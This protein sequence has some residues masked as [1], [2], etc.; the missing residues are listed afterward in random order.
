MSASTSS[1]RLG[2]PELVGEVG[3]VGLLAAAVALGSQG[4]LIGPV[5]LVAAVGVIAWR[6]LV[7]WHALL[8]AMIYVILFIPIRT[9]SLPGSLPIDLEPYRL[10]VAVVAGAWLAASLYDPRVRLYR[11]GVIDAPLTAFLVIVLVSVMVNLGRVRSVGSDAIKA[12]LFLATFVLVVYLVA[13]LVRTQEDLDRVV[14]VLVNGGA[15]VALACLIERRT[16]YNVFNHLSQVMPILKHSV[17]PVLIPDAR[18]A[19]VLGSS[20]HPI[21]MGVALVMLVPLA[22][23]RAFTTGGRL[24]WAAAALMVMGAMGTISR[25]AIVALGATALTMIVLK[26]RQMK[27][28]WP[29]IIPGLLLVHVAMPGT[30]GTIRAAF[31]PASGLIAQQSAAPVGSGRLA[32]LKPALRKE[33]LPDPLI[34]EGFGTRVTTP[35]SAVPVPNAPILDDEWLGILLET[36]AAGALAFL[37]IFVRFVRR[38]GGAARRDETSRGWFLAA[39]AASVV[40]YAVSM[41]LYDALSFIQVTFLLFILIGLGSVGYRLHLEDQPPRASAMRPG[42]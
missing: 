16:Q 13:S 3:I 35:D 24:A 32:T 30:L 6:S 18:G 15:V 7:T 4:R 28:M 39:V 10:I 9:Y 21:A 34:G 11:S 36:G 37:W 38:V 2:L 20:Q 40:G 19:R 26:P 41:L 14:R 1:P 23:Y 22:V 29:A 12:L 17:G 25:T 31:F 33:F 5:A 8:A 42:S 27:R